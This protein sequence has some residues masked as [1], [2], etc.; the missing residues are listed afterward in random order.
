MRSIKFCSE[1]AVK[2]KKNRAKLSLSSKRKKSVTPG[3]PAMP[4]LPELPPPQQPPLPEL[5]PPQQPPLQDMSPPETTSTP[6]RTNGGNNV[7]F[8]KTI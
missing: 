6:K 3:P 1:E 4:P 2:P 7:R 5:P 8:P